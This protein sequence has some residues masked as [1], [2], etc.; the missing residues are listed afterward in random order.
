MHSTRLPAK[1]K[2]TSSEISIESIEVGEDNNIF[3]EFTC[4]CFIGTLE[5]CSNGDIY[6]RDEDEEIHPIENQLAILKWVK[7]NIIK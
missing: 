5:I 4:R 1:D 3:V 7:N 6:L 2:V